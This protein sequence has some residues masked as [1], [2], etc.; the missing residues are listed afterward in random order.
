M[1][2]RRAFTLSITS[3]A[4][5]PKRCSAIPLATSPSPLSS[6]MPRRSSG[7]SS[8]R[9]TS[10]SKTGVP[11]STFSTMFERSEMLLTYPLP[12][13]TNSNSDNS[14]V[15]P[16]T[17]MLLPRTASR[18]FASGIFNDLKRFGST[19]ILYCLTKPPTLDLRY[20]RWPLGY[21]LPEDATPEVKAEVR[22]GRG[23]S[24]SSADAAPQRL[25]QIDDVLALRP[26]LRRDRLAGAFLVDEIH[27][28]R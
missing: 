18:T 28:R 5:W 8:I 15:R 7:P 11:F 24:R 13:T 12:R 27:Q 16:P 26:F 21:H 1:S 17:S 4:F 14:T 9:A 2:D 22:L 3:S 25:H 10:L 6:V 19:M 23:L 20:A